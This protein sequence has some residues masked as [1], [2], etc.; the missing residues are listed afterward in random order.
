M[1]SALSRTLFLIALHSETVLAEGACACL[2]SVRI[3]PGDVRK[4]MRTREAPVGASG[5]GRDAIPGTFT[6]RKPF[7]RP[8][9]WSSRVSAHCWKTCT[10]SLLNYLL[11]AGGFGHAINLSEVELMHLSQDLIWKCEGDLSQLSES[12]DEMKTFYT[13]ILVNVVFKK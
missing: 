1:L 12:C 2:V 11:T 8:A 9:F 6:N 10:S 3:L 13:D 5:T 4:A 7:S